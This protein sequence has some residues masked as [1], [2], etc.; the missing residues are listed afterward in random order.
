[1]SSKW[2][3]LKLGSSIIADFIRMTSVAVSSITSSAATIT[4]TTDRATTTQVQYRI[5]PPVADWTYTSYV[6][7]KVVSHTVNLTGLASGTT[8]EYQA[9]SDVQGIETYS[10]LQTFV[11]A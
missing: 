10:D 1:M 4:W 8:Y 2:M 5:H 3:G 11:T 6:Q 9:Y 7:A